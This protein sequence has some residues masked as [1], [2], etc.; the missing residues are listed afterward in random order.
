MIAVQKK[1]VL[2]CRGVHRTSALRIT[3]VQKSVIVR[4]GRHDGRPYEFEKILN[5]MCY[6]MERHIIR[7]F[8][9]YRGYF[10]KNE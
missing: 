2:I 8:Q 10:S 9:V 3:D 7:D 1:C 6:P 5:L 4:C